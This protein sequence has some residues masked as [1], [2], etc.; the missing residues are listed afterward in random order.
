MKKLFIVILILI[1]VLGIGNCFAIT[2][3]EFYLILDDATETLNSNKGLH[4]IFDGDFDLGYNTP[5]LSD[6]LSNIEN[7]NYFFSN[8][9]NNNQI[10]I[11]FYYS[12]SDTITLD[13]QYFSPLP[14]YCVRFSY[15][16][17]YPKPRMFLQS[18]ESI[19]FDEYTLSNNLIYN[20]NIIRNNVLYPANYELLPPY[21][22]PEFRQVNDITFPFRFY[23]EPIGFFHWHDLE[24][25]DLIFKIQKW[26]LEDTF[27]S[28]KTITNVVD[29][30]D[31]V[32]SLYID[33]NMMQCTTDAYYMLIALNEDGEIVCQSDP[34]TYTKENENV[35]IP[36]PGTITKTITPIDE[37]GDGEIDG[38]EI[39]E[40]DLTREEQTSTIIDG[41]NNITDRIEDKL[42]DTKNGIIGGIVNGIENVIKG[43]IEWFF[44]PSESQINDL[45]SQI[46]S[47][48]MI[49]ES[50]LG[51]P[52][53]LLKKF[54]DLFDEASYS[55]FVIEWDDIYLTFD[56]EETLIFSEYSFNIS[57]LIRDDETL[58]TYYTVYLVFIDFFC[59]CGFIWWCI[60]F[61]KDFLGVSESIPGANVFGAGDGQ[62]DKGES[63]ESSSDGEISDDEYFDSLNRYMTGKYGENWEYNPP[64]KK[65]QGSFK[66]YSKLRNQF[67]NKTRK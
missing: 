35:V 4:K 43:I 61:V 54:I 6:F 56:N 22:L 8:V 53:K 40:T 45:I 25:T 38:Y 39:E 63:S 15:A 46:D 29:I 62:T 9:I 16:S 17:Y 24:D 18:N 20:T 44:Q 2:E 1:C 60:G 13:S 31:G 19:T 5:T 21:F 58:S 66:A 67:L 41:I 32:V 28:E 47:S 23:D 36:S 57:Q 27:I 26:D 12:D 33:Y 7:C 42:E 34:F 3:E 37:D 14:N 10:N 59:A 48:D 51:F 49:N 55:D 52:L 50:L 11:I 64:L 65:G 30:S